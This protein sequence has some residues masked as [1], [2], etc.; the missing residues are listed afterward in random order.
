MCLKFSIENAR[1]ILL[2]KYEF[3]ENSYNKFHTSVREVNYILSVFY[4]SQW[5]SIKLRTK[6][7]HE[8]LLNDCKSA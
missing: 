8:H 5:I 1:I 2:R 7:I 4:V 3:S 6:D